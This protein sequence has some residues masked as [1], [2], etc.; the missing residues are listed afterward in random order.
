MGLKNINQFEQH[1]EKSVLGVAAA[2]E[3]AVRLAAAM[4]V[5]SGRKTIRGAGG[6]R[7]QA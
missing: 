6:R 7:H 2:G 3:V 1:A 5:S 4:A